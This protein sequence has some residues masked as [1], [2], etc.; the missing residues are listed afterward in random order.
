MTEIRV[1][2]NGLA[3]LQAL[4]DDL[5]V[6]GI[7]VGEWVE[8]DG[9]RVLVRLD[10]EFLEWDGERWTYNGKPVLPETFALEGA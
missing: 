1:N 5:A 6:R 7:A 3:E 2:V 9:E 4:D 8:R 10:P